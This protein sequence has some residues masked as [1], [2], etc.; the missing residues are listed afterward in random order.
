MRFLF[1]LALLLTASVSSAEI[2]SVR[3][4]I[5]GIYKN[6]CWTPIA[7][8]T[9]QGSGAGNVPVSI[10]T[11]DSDGT[12]TTF[13]GSGKTVYVKLGRASAPL[14]VD[15]GGADKTLHPSGNPAKQDRTA[16]F[17]F[18]EPVPCER[19]IYLIIGREDIGLQG[20][21]AELS[22]REDRRPLLV[23]VDSFAD[24]PDHWIGYEA[25]DM[26]V[27]T[28]SEPKQFEGLTSTSP[29]IK[30]LDDWVKLGG[31]LFFCAGRDSGPFLEP[32]NGALRPFLPGKFTK[33]TE[34]RKG[35]LLEE[36]SG[37]KRPIFMNGTSDAPFL[38]MPHFTDSQ[39]LTFVEDG[40]LPL[41]LRCAHG[42]GT[43]VYFGGDLSDKPLGNWRDRSQLVRNILQWNEERKAATQ[44]SQSLIQLGYNDISGQIRSALDKF[45]GV[46]II[47]FSIILILLAVYL[48]VVGLGDWF[49]VHKVFRRPILTW[50]TFPLWIVLFSGLAFW[51]AAPGRPNSPM[52][53]ELDVIDLDAGVIR[54]SSWANIYS[55]ADDYYSLHMTARTR[56]PTET[57]IHAIFAWNGLPGSGLGGMAPKTVSP[58]VWR[59]GSEHEAKRPFILE[60]VPIQIR[61][62]KSFFGQHWKFEA[63]NSARQSSLTDEDGIPVGTFVNPFEETLEDCLVV[64][65]RWVQK[66]GTVKPK[67]KVELGVRTERM[68]LRDVLYPKG[69]VRRLTSYNAQSGDLDY[70][71]RTMTLFNAIGGFEVIGLNNA[72]QRS[73]D[74]SPLL[75]VDRAILI[76]SVH[77]GETSEELLQPAIIGEEK[78]RWEGRR[79]VI[80]RQSIPVE[81]TERSPRLRRDAEREIKKDKLEGIDRTI[82]EGSEG[83]PF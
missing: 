71:V 57:G 19:P 67:E 62:T 30:A 16:P 52:L 9:D 26:V 83:K 13:Q 46:S 73:L 23:N 63:L 77:V 38:R 40:D 78:G 4:G 74:M 22:L 39:G 48:L 59:S 37:S 42:L 50:I 76:A 12:P 82:K 35:A 43:I 32:T 18:S 70:I 28:T 61:S 79:N 24:L 41:V 8:A 2:Y 47:P 68:E 58:T 55:P 44:T 11:V 1:F 56:K 54:C 36:F 66:L 33:M 5:D 6:G 81:L 21:I 51:L 31:R 60:N 15:D 27:L 72:F 3:V 7:V 14:T 65:G 80:V 20:A 29:Q 53:N 17:W 10:R 64:Y 69:A 34:L 45:D 75:T 25:V 49:L